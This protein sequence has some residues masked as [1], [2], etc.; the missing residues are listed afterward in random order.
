MQQ[1]LTQIPEAVNNWWQ[2]A[3]W[4][5]YCLVLWV[6][7]GWNYFIHEGSFELLKLYVD[8]M[9]SHAWG[10]EVLRFVRSHLTHQDMLTVAIVLTVASLLT[11]LLPLIVKKRISYS[12]WARIGRLMIALLAACLAISAFTVWAVWATSL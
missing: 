10:D 8:V 5:L 3:M 9:E 11:F 4:Y 2:Q 12:I 6:K 7:E 1:V